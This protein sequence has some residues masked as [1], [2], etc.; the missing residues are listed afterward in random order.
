M[1]KHWQNH[2]NGYLAG[3]INSTRLFV[4]TSEIFKGRVIFPKAL[5][6]QDEYFGKNYLSFVVS[7]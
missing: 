6:L 3:N 5:V 1:T 7:S 4:I 2:D